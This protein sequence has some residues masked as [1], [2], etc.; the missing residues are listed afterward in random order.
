VRVSPP[1]R[2]QRVAAGLSRHRS[3][4]GPDVPTHGDTDE[5]ERR[6]VDTLR[7]LVERADEIEPPPQV[8]LP[9][10]GSLSLELGMRPRDAFFGPAEQVSAKGRGGPDRGRN[11]QPLPARCPGRRAGRGD[12]PG[13]RRLPR[14]PSGKASAAT[15]QFR[16]AGLASAREL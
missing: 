12:Q 13:G 6:F 5:T 4:G 1:G 15:R 14:Q 16:A 8:D 9:P 7:Q 10:A 2:P 11:D 3:H